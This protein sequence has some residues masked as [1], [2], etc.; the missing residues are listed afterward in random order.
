MLV[1]AVVGEVVLQYLR[2]N[3]G[4]HDF[5]MKSY[6]A[7]FINILFIFTPINVYT[8]RNVATNFVRYK[9]RYQSQTKPVVYIVLNF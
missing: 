2:R 5:V 6:N 4:V 9:I 7:S 8:T 1:T 3:V